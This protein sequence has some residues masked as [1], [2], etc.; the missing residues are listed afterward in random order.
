MI[1]LDTQ[2]LANLDDWN[3]RMVNADFPV[4]HVVYIEKE[5]HMCQG[6]Y[7]DTEPYITL[8]ESNDMKWR[9]SEMLE[10]G[11]APNASK[12]TGIYRFGAGNKIKL[13][14]G[15]FFGLTTGVVR[16]DAITGEVSNYCNCCL[17]GPSYN[18]STYDFRAE[19]S[20]CTG[21][22]VTELYNSLSNMTAEQ[23]DAQYPAY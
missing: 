1:K 22:E 8:C 3:K 12:K 14:S 23:L 6:C 21:S 7:E 16:L 2:P 15:Y 4:D 18:G 9:N 10:K 13:P 20:A 11:S 17:Y 19:F 5:V